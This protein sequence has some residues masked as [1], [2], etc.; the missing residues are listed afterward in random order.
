[1]RHPKDYRQK[2]YDYVE[3]LLGRPLTFE[4]HDDL[5]DMMNEY[6]FSATNLRATV[7]RVFCRHEWTSDKMIEGGGRQTRA[8]VKCVR[9]DKRSMKHMPT[10]SF[11]V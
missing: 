1:M 4:E 9:C 3:E 6:V 2:V 5:R 7:R 11:D 8:Y 10:I